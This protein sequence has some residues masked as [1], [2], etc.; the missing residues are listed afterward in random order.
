MILSGHVCLPPASSGGWTS[1][2]NFER[3]GMV[4]TR[5]YPR[6]DRCSNFPLRSYRRRH[7]RLRR[8]TL[9]DTSQT[10]QKL[11]N[12]NWAELL[13]AMLTPTFNTQR[14]FFGT[15]EQEDGQDTDQT[16][17]TTDYTVCESEL[18]LSEP[19]PI[20]TNFHPNYHTFPH[21]THFLPGEQIYI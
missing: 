12:W 10:S 16:R 14:M 17:S 6:R 19:Q 13:T 20:Y 21:Q 11:E 15:L 9:Q 4:R 1:G 5:C 18:P 7:F 2:K 3:A 8:D